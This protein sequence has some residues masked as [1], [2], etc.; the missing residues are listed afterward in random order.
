MKSTFKIG[1]FFSRLVPTFFTPVIRGPDPVD[2][3]RK[4]SFGTLT[5][6]RVLRSI[7]NALFLEKN[8]IF[9]DYR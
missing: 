8:K 2:F 9:Y 4:N 7:R 5:S 1:K 3:E 6:N